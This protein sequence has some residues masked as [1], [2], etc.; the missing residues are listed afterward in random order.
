[1]CMPYERMGRL[2]RGRTLYQKGHLISQMLVNKLGVLIRSIFQKSVNAFV[3]I[4]FSWK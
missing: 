1:M 2:Q 3:V 4:P